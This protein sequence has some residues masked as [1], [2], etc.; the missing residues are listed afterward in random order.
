VVTV[1]AAVFAAEIPSPTHIAGVVVISAGLGSLVF[2]RGPNR[3]GLAGGRAA[4]LAAVGTGLT[5]ASYTV[6]DGFGVRRSHSAAGYTGW[7]ILLE[8]LDSAIIAVVWRW[9]RP[10]GASRNVFAGQS[11]RTLAT[12]CLAGALSLLAYGLVLWAQTRGA[13]APIAAVRETSIIFGAI[14]GA[15]MFHERFGRVRIVAAAVVVAGIAL[16]SV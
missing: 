16:V 11:A 8:S 12:G 4:L 7:L 10:T 14:I 3:S 9:F 5:I 1:L 15:L 6:V 13:L 2:A